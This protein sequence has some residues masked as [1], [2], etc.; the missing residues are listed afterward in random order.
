MDTTFDPHLTHNP[1]R[2]SIWQKIGGGALTLAVV[3]HAILLVVGAIW[4]FQVIR[5]PDKKVNFMPNGGGGGGGERGAKTQVQQ[6]KR[7][8]ITPSTNVKR[9]FAEGASSNFALPDPGDFFG[10]MSALGS[11][12]GGGLGGFGGAGSGGGFGR[13]T[14]PASS[15]IGVPGGQGIANPFGRVVPDANALEGTFYDLKQTRNKQSTDM[16]NE[17]VKEVIRDFVTHGWRERSLSKYYK[18]GRT[19]YQNRL[20]IPMMPA[21]KAP[22]AFDCEK[23]VQPSRWIVVY[24]GVV[25][26]PK[27]GRY[28]F[29]GA[30]DDVLVVRFNGRHVFDHGYTSGTLGSD[31]LG[32]VDFFKGN[33]E[34]DTL[35]KLARRVYPMDL[36]VR[37]YEYDTTKNWNHDIGGLAV[38]AEFEA[39]AGKTYPIDILISEIPGGLFCASLL[40]E[41]VGINYQKTPTGAPVLPIFRLDGGLPAPAK[42]DNAPPYDPE[43]PVWKRVKG[44]GFA[45][46]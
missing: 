15:G 33:K 20:M 18:A 16:T 43:G 31:I 34:N 22:A 41:E 36:P 13:D 4:I 21:D 28:R 8:Q 24:R 44:S 19:L 32:N 3:V 12:G 2:V 40:I 38:G 6:K 10:E 42:A 9:V 17:G 1:P 11:L 5:E 23:E 37:Y 27:T 45:D 25:T 35:K 29:V 7:A 14:G 26:P 46:F 30:G 39:V